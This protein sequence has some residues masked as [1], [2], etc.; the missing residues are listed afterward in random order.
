VATASNEGRC[1][2]CHIGIGWK[3]DSFDFSNASNID[4]LICHD[5]TGTYKKHPSAAGGGGPPAMMIDGELTVVGPEDLQ[6]VAYNVGPPTRANCGACHFNAGGG[7]NVKHGDLA[8]SLIEPTFDMDVHMGSIETGGRNY[9][10]QRCHTTT[11]HRIAGATALHSNE[12]T[13]ACADCHGATNVHNQ[14]VLNLH[15]DAVACQACHIPSFSRQKP[16]VMEWYWDEAGQ[17]IDPIPTDE[18]G[19][20]TYNKMKGRFVWDK[21]V[22]PTLLWFNGTYR[23]LLVGTDDQYA[24]TP[25]VLA[26]PVG[27]FNDLTAKLYPFKKLIGKQPAD[28]VNHTMLVPH[29]FGTAGGANPYWATYDWGPA[30]EEGAAA[31]GQTYS[32][33]YEWVDTVMYLRVNHEVAPKEMALD[34]EDCHAGGIDFEA[35]GYERDPWEVEVRGFSETGNGS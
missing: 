6:E 10:C 21:D 26:E 2:Q 32:G 20:P 29:L 12:G 22:R 23:R 24:T 3:D 13:V 28:A 5:T 1:T 25:V 30:L 4:C 17:D 14:Q 31:A 19:M 35:L 18:F 33:Q 7:D 15:L 9:A 34:C 8:S 16:T 27:D 11:N